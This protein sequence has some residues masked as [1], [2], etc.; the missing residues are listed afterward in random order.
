MIKKEPYYNWMEMHKIKTHNIEKHEVQYEDYAYQLKEELSKV[1]LNKGYIIKSIQTMKHSVLPGIYDE[2][3]IICA[4]D[5]PYYFESI[6]DNSIAMKTDE[7]CIKTYINFLP[8]SSYQYVYIPYGMYYSEDE[9]RSNPYIDR[10][11]KKLCDDVKVETDEEM[12]LTELIN[13]AKGLTKE[14]YINQIVIQHSKEIRNIYGR[15]IEFYRIDKSKFNINNN[16]NF[17]DKDSRKEI[18]IREKVLSIF[19]KKNSKL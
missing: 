3:Y 7:V 2:Y 15:A 14:E 17:K 1:L 19:N 10:Y 12:V 5:K 16:H 18:K 11:P 13:W 9:Y 6:E 4:F 8:I